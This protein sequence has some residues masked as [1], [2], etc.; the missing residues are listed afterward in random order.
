MKWGPALLPAPTAPSE[1][2]AEPH[3]QVPGEPN[4]E[5]RLTS[6][7]VASHRQLPPGEERDRPTEVRGPKARI[8]FERSCL[9]RR[10][11][12][13]WC[14]AALLGMI[15][16]A[17]RFASTG[18]KAGFS[19]V[20]RS[21][22]HLFR[23][24]VPAGLETL[25][26]EPLIA[27]RGDRTFGHLPHRPA[28]ADCLARPGPPSR[29]PAHHAHPVRVAKAKNAGAGLWITGISGTRTGTISDSFAS[30]VLQ[31]PG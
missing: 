8:S 31:A 22:D 21:E 16:T 19:R 4:I 15:S 18:P 25:P 24:L 27:C 1:G 23:R 29:S 5:L 11:K 30:A 6:S 2:S 10:P 20:A 17:S 26:K 7:G 9:A 13:T 3:H 28:V 12:P 14:S